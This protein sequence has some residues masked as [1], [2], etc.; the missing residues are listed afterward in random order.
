MAVA[1]FQNK[2]VTNRPQNLVFLDDLG[3]IPKEGDGVNV[4]G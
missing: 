4:D 2:E 3:F 1:E